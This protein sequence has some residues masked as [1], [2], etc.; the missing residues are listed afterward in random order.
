MPFVEQLAPPRW[1]SSRRTAC[2][3][4]GRAVGSLFSVCV[5]RVMRCRDRGVLTFGL[6][7]VPCAFVGISAGAVPCCGCF[8]KHRVGVVASSGVILCAGGSVVRCCR[9]VV[10]FFVAFGRA[11]NIILC[12]R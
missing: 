10:G 9:V 2:L 11:A 7:R 8:V 12:D 4:L 5:V 1:P 6:S 3:L